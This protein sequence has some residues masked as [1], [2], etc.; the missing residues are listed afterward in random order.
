MGHTNGFSYVRLYC[1][2]LGSSSSLPST[3]L[4]TNDF[5]PTGLLARV[6]QGDA[7]QVGWTGAPKENPPD[8]AGPTQSPV[9]TGYDI[10]LRLLGG[11]DLGGDLI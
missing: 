2:V 11:H 3:K 4:N 7:F 6:C 5:F 9:P 8:L 1:F 10:N